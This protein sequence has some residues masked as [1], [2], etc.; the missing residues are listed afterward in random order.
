MMVL[1]LLGLSKVKGNL[2]SGTLSFLDGL[3]DC[4]DVLKG[5]ALFAAWWIVFVW[6]VLT[7]MNL[8]LYR[9][10]FVIFS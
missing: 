10:G 2:F 5:M 1:L 6:A 8:A 7:M 3:Q 9:C 4:S